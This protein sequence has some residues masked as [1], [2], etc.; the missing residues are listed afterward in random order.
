M[1]TVTYTAT[2][3]LQDIIA[4]Q[5]AGKLAMFRVTSHRDENCLGEHLVFINGHAQ[6]CVTRERVSVKGAGLHFVSYCDAKDLS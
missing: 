4:K 1:T 5:P 6:Q 2:T 3:S